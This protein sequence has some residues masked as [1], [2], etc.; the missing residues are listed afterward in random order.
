MVNGSSL[1]EAAVSIVSSSQHPFNKLMRRGFF[2]TEM[3]Q[4]HLSLTS[5][6]WVVD[7]QRSMSANQDVIQ[8]PGGLQLLNCPNFF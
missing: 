3:A 8:V 4:G 7:R 2:E 5:T 1:K 6:C